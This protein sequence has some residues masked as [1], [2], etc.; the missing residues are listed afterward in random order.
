MSLTKYEL[1]V[2]KLEMELK[3]KRVAK[4]LYLTMKYF[5][6]DNISFNKVF[7]SSFDNIVFDKKDILYIKKRSKED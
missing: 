5:K 7:N 1:E 2:K 6:Y 4:E 3:A